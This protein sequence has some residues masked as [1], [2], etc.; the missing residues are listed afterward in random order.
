[1]KARTAFVSFAMVLAL[2]AGAC[3]RQ[4]PSEQLAARP[5]A[6]PTELEGVPCAAGKAWFDATGKLASCVLSR[7]ATVGAV[8]LPGGTWLHLTRDGKPDYCFLPRDSVIQGHRCKGSGHSYMTAFQP[9]GALEL[10]WLAED[11]TI[12]GV[13]CMQASFLSEVFGGG[14]GTYFHE[15]GTVAR[16]KLAADTTISGRSLHR[17]DHVA[18]DRAGKLVESK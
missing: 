8:Q 12:H 13:P 5:L 18:L 15:D 6:Q 14:A 2:C 1:M 4:R 16:C 9:G 10:C 3:S 7:D 11:E 17:G